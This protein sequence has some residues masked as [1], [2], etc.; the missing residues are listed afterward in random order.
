M[1]DRNSHMR[2][3]V[4]WSAFYSYS[5]ETRRLMKWWCHVVLWS[6]AALGRRSVFGKLLG[7]GEKNVMSCLALG[8]YTRPQ[9]ID[10]D[11]I[12]LLLFGTR[13]F[14]FMPDDTSS[15]KIIFRHWS[16]PRWTCHLYLVCLR[17]LLVVWQNMLVLCGHAVR[18]RVGPWY[19]LAIE[20]RLKGRWSEQNGL[21]QKQRANWQQ[22]DVLF[23][24]RTVA[25]SCAAFVVKLFI[26]SV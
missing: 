13:G 2:E 8:K 15:S 21:P 24:C 22:K 20:K 17:S 3:F 19:V 4:L 11:S 5:L 7:H 10:D 14:T 16:P 18:H 12:F 25:R 26:Y 1:G 6:P 9:A 23:H